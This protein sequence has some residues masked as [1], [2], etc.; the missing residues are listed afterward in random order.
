MTAPSTSAIRD[1][2]DLAEPARGEYRPQLDSLRA[3]AVFGVI[4]GHLASSATDVLPLGELGV[5]IHEMDIDGSYYGVVNFFEK[6]AKLQRII[7]VNGLQI[8][9]VKKP[10]DAKVKGTYTYAPTESV[11]ADCTTTTFFSQDSG[12]LQPAGAAAAKK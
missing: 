5:P 2:V 11:V 6:V 4:I 3:F 1:R 10:S 8:A 12:T 9:T 7:N